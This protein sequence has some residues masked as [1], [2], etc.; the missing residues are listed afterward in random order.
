MTSPVFV[1]GASRSGTTMLRLMLSAHP[2]IG[3]PPE[4]G[5]LVRLGWRYG[6][7]PALGAGDLRRFVRDLFALET[8][9]DWEL[10]RAELEERLLRLAPLPY[11][12]AAE[13][14]YLEYLR[15]KFPGKS[16]WGDKTTWYCDYP[17]TLD[18]YFPHAR[19]VHLTRDGRGVVASF[20][21]VAH[22]PGDVAVV[23]TQWAVVNRRVQT[24][25]GRIGAARYLRVRYEDVVTDP[26]P[27]LR[28]ICEF[29]GEPFAPE[30]LEFWRFNRERQLEPER[31]MGWKSLTLEPVRAERAS[32]FAR[33]L[34]PED[35]ATFWL[36]AGRTMRALG[37]DGGRA[38][39]PR[40]RVAR[41][42][43]RAGLEWLDATVRRALRPLKGRLPAALE[44]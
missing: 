29:L 4:S 25:G 11:A 26:E 34:T 14:V 33:D 36:V 40:P 31:H 3:V 32:S 20:R 22:L 37:Y 41:V 38:G 5:F 44:R 6:A 27:Q 1:L 30:M 42:A 39:L 19:F 43:L 24:F 17:E 15:R 9:Q 18:R 7:V 28:R 10:D 23:A 21:K 16:R 35:E 2:H 8:T 13:E 12:R